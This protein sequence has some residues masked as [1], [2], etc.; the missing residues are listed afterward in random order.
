[1]A[2]HQDK[3]IPPTRDI[4]ARVVYGTSHLGEFDRDQ[5]EAE[6]RGDEPAIA[7][8]T[9]AIKHALDDLDVLRMDPR[10]VEV[11]G[12]DPETQAARYRASQPS[13]SVFDVPLAQG[14]ALALL[15]RADLSTP[16]GADRYRAQLRVAPFEDDTGRR[17]GI[18]PSIEQLRLAQEI[19]NALATAI[20]H[21]DN[22]DNWELV[23]RA[24]G[25]LL[26][27]VLPRRAAV[28]SIIDDLI[29]FQRETKAAHDWA[30]ERCRPVNDESQHEVGRAT[31]AIRRLAAV[32]PGFGVVEP[33]D[34]LDMIRRGDRSAIGIAAQLSLRTGAFDDGR[35]E[36]DTGDATHRRIRQ[37]YEKARLTMPNS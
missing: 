11:R 1:M 3:R 35:R 9:S 31:E 18:P 6:T 29:T 8:A 19:G 4:E 21:G 28:L 22:P 13:D 24:H 37:L 36:S 23:R 12:V 14:G 34:L 17:N 10:A 25:E 7:K 16:A 5:L 20:L 2:D 15:M 27:G 26:R 30:R 33:R 32:H